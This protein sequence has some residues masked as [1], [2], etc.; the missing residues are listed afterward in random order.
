MVETG[1][2]TRSRNWTPCSLRTPTMLASVK[3]CAS[4]CAAWH[5]KRARTVSKL[6]TSISGGFSVP[7]YP[8]Q[9]TAYPADQ[10][11]PSTGGTTLARTVAGRLAQCFATKA[12]SGSSSPVRDETAPDFAA[13]G[14]AICC[15]LVRRIAGYVNQ[16]ES[17][18][19]IRR[20][21]AV[22]PADQ[23]SRGGL[24]ARS[25]GP[26]QSCPETGG[27]TKSGRKL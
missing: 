3:A 11:P 8:S 27:H 7:T 2:N 23:R 26:R 6:H 1:L 25:E 19:G 10:W 20:L 18:W 12:K 24:V 14:M 17:P 15:K 5:A 9:V 21:P 16:F 4:E 22:A 13:P